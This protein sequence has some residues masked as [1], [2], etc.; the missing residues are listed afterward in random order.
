MSNRADARAKVLANLSHA[1]IRWGALRKAA[2]L[3]CDDMREAIRTL[4]SEGRIV[5]EGE[6][7]TRL[8]RLPHK[9]EQVQDQMEAKRAYWTASKRA[10]R[11]RKRAELK[12]AGT[13]RGPGR[14]TV[15]DAQRFKLTSA[16]KQAVQMRLDTPP[17]LYAPVSEPGERETV[18]QFMARGGHIERLDPGA[19]S[20]RGHLIELF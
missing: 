14:R 9:G 12:A 1:S 17:S 10:Q 3:S 8:Y 2:G 19:C 18:E 4:V 5:A 15:T 13:Y 6:V 16:R 7:G 20:A 11:E